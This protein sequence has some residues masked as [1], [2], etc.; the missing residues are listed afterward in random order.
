MVEWS[1]NRLLQN[2][3]FQPWLHITDTWGALK[4]PSD[5]ATPYTNYIRTSGGKIQASVIFKALQVIH[6]SVQPWLR[7]TALKRKC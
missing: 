3:G 1:V 6:S 5:Q 7:M 4:N 2:T